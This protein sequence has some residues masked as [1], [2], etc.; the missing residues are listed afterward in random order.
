MATK[1]GFHPAHPLPLV[2]ADQIE[3]QDTENARDGVVGPSRVFKASVLIAAAVIATGIA[4][5]SLGDPL[6]LYADVTAALVG[7]SELQPDTDQSIPKNQSVVGA[8]ALAQSTANPEA[9]PPTVKDVRTRDEIATVEPA[10]KD[11]TEERMPTSEA[12]FRQFQAWATEQDAQTNAK[13]TIQD[14]PAQ[15]GK[16]VAGNAP[17]QRRLIQKRKQILP[18]NNARAEVRTERL[19][20]KVR[21]APTA[22]V[23]RPP[24]ENARTEG[25]SVQDARASFLPTSGLRN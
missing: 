16:K 18:V 4:V 21:R 20:K 19:R 10:V 22:R 25:Q 8:P 6:A 14:V 12:L 17:V 15:V 2:P 9:L 23:E 1:E 3:Q 24:A 11:Q 7:N 5:L 13:P